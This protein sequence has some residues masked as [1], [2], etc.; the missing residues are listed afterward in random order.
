VGDGLRILNA[1]LTLLRD[2]RPLTFFGG[3]GLVA[4]VLGLAPGLFVT[5]EYT[6]TGMV[7]IPTAV[8]ATGLEIVGLGLVLTGVILTTVARRFRELDHQIAGLERR[9]RRSV[10]HRGAGAKDP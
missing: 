7:R 9:V 6:R 8:L 1:I 4:I 10:P 2:Y 3:L 5:W